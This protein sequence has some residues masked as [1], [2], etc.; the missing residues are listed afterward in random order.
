MLDLGDVLKAKRQDSLG[1]LSGLVSSVFFEMFGDIRQNPK[2]LPV[3]PLGE[4]CARI[5]D[6][7]HQSPTWSDAGCPFLFVKNIIS[8]EIEFDTDKF[9]SSETHHELTQRCPI[10]VGDVLYSTV[11][12]YGVPAMVRTPRKFAFQRHIAHL[13][14]NRLAVRS[15]YLRAALASTDVRAQADRVARGVAQKTLNLGEIERL[16]VLRPTLDEQDQ[17]ASAIARIEQLERVQADHLAWVNTLFASLQSR[18][19]AG[20]L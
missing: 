10:E 16:S 11:G 9:I 8:G 6:G 3:V 12:S 4:L 17:F 2:R 18:A 13:K 7:T 5:T 19:F 20:E 15:E 14:P 1:H